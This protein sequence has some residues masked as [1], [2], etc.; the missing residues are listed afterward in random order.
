[1]SLQI[2]SRPPMKTHD[3][4]KQKSS[5]GPVWKRGGNADVSCKSI[6]TSITIQ[7]VWRLKCVHTLI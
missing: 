2:E 5:E 7:T 4:L 6:L 3:K 1:M